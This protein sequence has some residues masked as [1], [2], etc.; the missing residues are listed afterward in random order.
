MTPPWH[1]VG[2]KGGPIILILLRRDP[3]AHSARSVSICTFLTR[4]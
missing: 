1:P 2:C 4:P 3:L